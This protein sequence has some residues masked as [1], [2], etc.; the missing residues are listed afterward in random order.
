MA[1]RPLFIPC[2]TG[3][4]LVET[5][6]VDFEWHP[7][8]AASQKRKSVASL[9]QAARDS[10]GLERIL[11]VSTKSQEALGEALSAFN[12]MYTVGS[13]GRQYS[14]EVIFQS[15]KVFSH[16]GPYLDMRG[17][18]PAEAKQDPRLKESGSLVKFSSG[19]LDWPLEPPTAFYD[20]LYLN[21][22]KS[23]PQLVKQLVGYQA[24]TDIEFN[25]KKSINCQAYSVALFVAL[26]ARGILQEALSSQQ[27]F[28]ECIS[29][30]ERGITTEASSATKSLL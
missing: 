18:S 1:E 8:M 14:L 7:G 9:H 3:E 22:L 15:A 6:L 20:W 23:Q 16:G 5:Q 2:T 12:L 29:S 21:I 4:R 25:P 19:G 28:L 27:A 24:F 11:E 13:T 17:M 10:L 30:Y 26:D